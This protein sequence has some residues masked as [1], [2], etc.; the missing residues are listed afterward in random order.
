MKKRIRR[1]LEDVLDTLER[2]DCKFWACP[3][4][5]SNRIYTMKTCVLCAQ[6]IEIRRILRKEDKCLKT[7]NR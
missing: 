2:V 1:L 6:I 5:D 3:G 4:P 7:I